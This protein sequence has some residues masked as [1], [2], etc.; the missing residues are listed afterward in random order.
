MIFY[1]TGTG[2][3]MYAAKQLQ[4]EGERVVS[5]GETVTSR[6]FTYELEAG[7]KL[8]FVFPV[9][10]W[11]LPNIIPWFIR[12]LQLTGEAPSYVYAVITCG[13]SI[14]G[15]DRM[16]KEE[17]GKSGYPLDVVYDVKMPDNYVLM[18]DVPGEEEQKKILE[19]SRKR[20]E[21]IRENLTVCHGDG[22][23]R[24]GW[25]QQL[26]T[27]ALYPLYRYGRKTDQ[28][29]TDDRC[30]GCGA[31]AERCSCHAIQ[32][33]NGKP[34]W[35]KDRCILCLG[36]TNRCGAIQYGKKTVERGRYVHPILQKKKHAH[37]SCHEQQ[38]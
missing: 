37:T 28:F 6:A 25:K 11:G 9:Y 29:Y 1:F 30:I 17:L 33:I 7:E 35:V 2:N 8:G 20:L 10:F 36:C 32:M 31:C 4:K 15:A 3:S 16:L 12:K 27:K 13:G 24:S 21:E 19:E 5:I 18:Y 14:G 34:T 38:K 26:L 22:G 23:Y